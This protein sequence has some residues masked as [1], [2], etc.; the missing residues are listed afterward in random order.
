MN[1]K[2]SLM[3]DIN[4]LKSGLIVHTDG[5]LRQRLR[6]PFLKRFSAKL[7][8][9]NLRLANDFTVIWLSLMGWYAAHNFARLIYCRFVR[10]NPNLSGHL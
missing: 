10:S 6:R 7:I 8:Q 1:L 3:H 9:G 2:M 5:N 4:S